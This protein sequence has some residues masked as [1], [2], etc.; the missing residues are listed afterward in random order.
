M[1]TEDWV[2]EIGSSAFLALEEMLSI[3]DEEERRETIEQDPLEV[4]VRSAWCNPRDNGIMRPVEY[5]ILLSTGGPAT[6]IT[7]KLDQYL[8]PVSARLEVQDWS[9]PW[10]EYPCDEEKLL[11]YAGFFYYGS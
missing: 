1:T 6:R 9:K 8:E 2:K 7:G 11:E 4:Q 10:T 3:E 5:M